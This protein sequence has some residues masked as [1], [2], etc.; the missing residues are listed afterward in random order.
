MAFN[1]AKLLRTIGRALVGQLKQ[2]APAILDRAKDE[3]TK[4]ATTE[5]VSRAEALKAKLDRKSEGVQ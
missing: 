2:E 3:L 1:F 5:I 4:K